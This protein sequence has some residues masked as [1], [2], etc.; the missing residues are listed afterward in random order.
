M[1]KHA[2][3]DLPEEIYDRLRD[4]AAISGRSEA[5]FMLEAVQ[6]AIEDIEDLRD[7]E[8]ITQRRLKG[9]SKTY[10]LEEVSRRLGLED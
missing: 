4:A 8:E 5:E 3:I 6:Q 9:E 7:A 2:V 1:T 10:T